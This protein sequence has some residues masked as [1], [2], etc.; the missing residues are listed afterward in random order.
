[1]PAQQL[2]EEPFFAATDA[3][4]TSFEA[5]MTCGGD[6]RSL[7]L[8]TGTNKYHIRPQPVDPAHVFR[9]S[10]TGNPPTQRGYDAAKK[11]FDKLPGLDDKSLDETLGPVI[12]DQR[13]RLTKL[14]D[15]PEGSEVIMCPSGSDAEYI[16]IAIARALKGDIPISNGVVQVR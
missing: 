3:G 10:C 11:L 15:L 4:Y 2:D 13:A 14:L 5:C 1:M 6:D 8:E 7:I 16:P 9:G 12:E